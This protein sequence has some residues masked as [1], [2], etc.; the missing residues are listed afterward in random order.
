MDVEE[1][2]G[3]AAGREE[4]QAPLAEVGQVARE[5][6][7]ERAYQVGEDPLA[8]DAP[9]RVPRVERHQVLEPREGP[10]ERAHLRA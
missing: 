6:G 8:V 2:P 4:A 10:G 5:A 3:R 7:A 1:E 9:R